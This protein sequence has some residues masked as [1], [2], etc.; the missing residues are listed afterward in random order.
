[1]LFIIDECH[2]SQFGKMHGYIK[3]HFHNGNYIDFTGTS[4]FKK[5]NG[6]SSRTT[7]GM[8]S[9]ETFDRYVH[10]YMIKEAIADG[11]ILRF[12]C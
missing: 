10:R 6:G 7:A 8:F 12:F 9:A 1:M 5:N 4:I 3:W 11:N 2:R